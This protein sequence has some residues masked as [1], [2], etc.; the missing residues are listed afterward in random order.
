M[1]PRKSTAKVVVETLAESRSAD[2]TPAE[3][4]PRAGSFRT[5]G[6][7]ATHVKRDRDCAPRFSPSKLPMLTKLVPSFAIC[8]ALPASYHRISGCGPVP[9]LAMSRTLTAEA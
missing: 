9:R 4:G 1:N 7:E 8:Q 6:A 2:V 3:L 5:I